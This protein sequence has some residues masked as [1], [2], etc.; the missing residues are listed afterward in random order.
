[1]SVLQAVRGQVRQISHARTG[2]MATVQTLF[3]NMFILVLNV[4]NGIIIARGL[5]PSGRGEQAVM[6]LWPQF[7]AGVLTL[8]LPAAVTYN[9]KRFPEE[10]RTL[11]S[12]GL[13]LSAGLGGAAALFGVAALAYFLKQYPPSLVFAAQWL[14]LVT[15]TT[16]I[17]YF[18]NAVL[19]NHH[20]FSLL[21]RLRYLPPLLTLVLLLYFLASHTLTPLTAVLSFVLTG[22]PGFLWLFVR[23]VRQ[24]PPL[25]S[26]LGAAY[27]KLL[28][29]GLRAYGIDLLGTLSAQIDQVL[30]VGLLASRQMGLYATALG[31]SRMLN[32]VQS[33]I[34]NVLFP[35]AMN[36]P[37]EEVVLLIGRTARVSSLCTFAFAVFAALV[38]P[39][40][41]HILYGNAYMESVGVFRILVFEVVVSS[42]VW[43]LGQAFMATGHPGTVTLLQTVG[44]LLS[45]PLMLVLIPRYGL[46]GAGTAILLSSLLRLALILLN[47]PLTLKVAPPGCFL[48]RADIRWVRGSLRGT[49]GS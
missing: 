34:V 31:L 4:A 16:L 45:V 11:F 29:Y 7:L 25:V 5:G 26:G 28:H 27:R 35:K 49:K 9:M 40:V 33:A 43:V 17:A 36:R 39:V 44:L 23:L 14:M 18:L 13:W 3:V 46:M 24:Y 30:V 19:Q 42:L 41:L 1:M 8:G 37:V 20:E 12:A 22:V 10:A 48:T 47:F 15:P 38:G 21:N 6:A 2:F 32:F